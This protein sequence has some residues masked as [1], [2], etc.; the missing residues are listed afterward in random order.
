[1]IVRIM[2]EGQVEISADDIGVLNELDTELETAIETDDEAVFR[3]KLHAL[4][5][6]VRHVGKALP[7]DSL[8]PS[9]LILP[10]A[11][12][13]IEEV[14]EMLGDQGLIPG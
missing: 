3:E 8:E 4:L 12:A 5:D 1:M 6:K 14:R 10:P 13:S 9:E 11:D 7:D 2:G